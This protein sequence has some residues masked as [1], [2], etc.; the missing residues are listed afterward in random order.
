MADRHKTR[1][2]LQQH[3][4]LIPEIES[5]TPEAEPELIT[6]PA[7]PTPTVKVVEEVP[8]EAR[9][10]NSG[11]SSTTTVPGPAAPPGSV[12][13]VPTGAPTDSEVDGEALVA[14][15]E[16]FIADF[17]IL[18][19]G[20]S[21]PLTVWVV[22][23]YCYKT[24]DSFAYLLVTSPAPRC[25][26]TRLLE[27]LSLIVSTPRRTA[28]I[29]ESALFRVIEKFAPT[30]L[31]DE[32]ENLRGKGERA[33]YLRG[34]INAGNRADATVMRCVGK[35]FDPKEFS[36]FCP[37]VISGIGHFPHTIK[38]RSIVVGMQRRKAEEK[39]RRFIF[40]E[41]RPI[42]EEL[43]RRAQMFIERERQQVERAYTSLD[44]Q[45]LEDREAEVWEPLFALLGVAD[46]SR[47]AELRTCAE[48]LCRQKA[49]ADADENLAVKLLS[50]L[51]DVWP[52]KRTHVWTRDLLG[53]LRALEER[54]WSTESD[55][56]PR[57]MA[58]LLRG[59]EIRTRKV[60]VGDSTGKGYLLGELEA[61]FR[62]YLPPD[63]LEREH[64]EQP[65]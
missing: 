34:L 47:V 22:G 4:K 41:A 30:L 26:K 42:G 18:P 27:V 65:A 56:N 3:P 59:F 45:F 31:L 35:D 43:R 7:P 50:D 55:L 28:N 39:L 29:S 54:P 19:A 2:F 49:S 16:R 48:Q 10:V 32:A 23:T 13:S 33:E 62:R 58:R 57:K 12:T 40:R 37:K 11:H 8:E 38:D 52:E 25:G 1:E 51:R 21:L 15:I 24:F 53:L 44:L 46:P 20:T 36:V 64:G 14:D 9:R 5:F 6:A 60:R 61:A 63:G 17:V